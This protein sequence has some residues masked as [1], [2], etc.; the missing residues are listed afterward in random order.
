VAA[1]VRLAGDA[2]VDAI[3]EIYRP[4]VE[5]TAIS[6]ETRAPDRAE[7]SRR[8]CDTLESL[9][10]LVCEID[11]VVAGFAYAARHR[12]REAY[13]W[14]VDTSVY[15]ES[16]YRRR[17]IGRGLYESLFAILEAQGFFNAYAGIALPNPSS[18][19]LHE[20]VG[21]ERIGVFRRVGYKLGRWH[22]VGWWERALRPH[23]PS[24]EKPSELAVVRR[25]PNWEILLTCGQRA[26]RERDSRR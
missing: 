23:R 20:S 12:L 7:M 15:V 4:I 10:W 3:T 24:P 17:G 8:V 26:I 6:F 25:Q 16:A 2:D 19:A 21:F 1:G 22:D 18:V 5:S 14:S 13:Q 9:P 11:G